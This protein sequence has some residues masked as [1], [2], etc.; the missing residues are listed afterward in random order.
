MREE[1]RLNAVYCGGRR[2]CA[3]APRSSA[4]ETTLMLPL[5]G[6]VLLPFARTAVMPCHRIGTFYIRFYLSVFDKEE[7]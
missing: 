4:E 1:I 6:K 5:A 7:T 3:G 2:P